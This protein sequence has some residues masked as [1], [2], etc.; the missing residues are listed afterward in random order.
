MTVGQHCTRPVATVPPDI[1]VQEAAR[2]MQGR[3]EGCLVVVDPSQRPIGF[4]TGRDLAL[5]VVGA[6]RRASAVRVEE[7]MSR[8]VLTISD[9][10]S[11]EEATRTL[12]ASAVRRLAVVNAD[13]QL[14]GIVTAGD[15]I[16]LLRKDL[17]QFEADLLI[18]P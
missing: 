11:I 5:K 18:A 15:L 12:K 6:A 17:N 7:V 13:G 14:R 4:L 2:L 1:H 3:P 16:L 10:A 9:T 8:P